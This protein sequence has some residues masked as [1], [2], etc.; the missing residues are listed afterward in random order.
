MS[1]LWSLYFCSLFYGFSMLWTC[2]EMSLFMADNVC[3]ILKPKVTNWTGP[4]TVTL[5][6]HNLNSVC[7]K[8]Q[9]LHKDCV[10]TLCVWEVYCPVQSCSLSC[11]SR[12]HDCLATNFKPKNDKL[13]WR[14]GL[15]RIPSSFVLHRR[16]EELQWEPGPDPHLPIC[17]CQ[18]LKGW[19]WA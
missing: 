13:P 7:A 3:E 17:G 10:P 6:A 16:Q 1:W 2:E 18:M 11:H 8:C 4:L 19:W 14:T 9:I 15:C 5:I 12:F